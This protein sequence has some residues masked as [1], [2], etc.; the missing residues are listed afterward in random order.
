MIIM[1]CKNIQKTIFSVLT[2]NKFIIIKDKDLYFI[3]F[4]YIFSN[5]QLLSELACIMDIFL[6]ISKYPTHL[7]IYAIIKYAKCIKE[8]HFEGTVLEFVCFY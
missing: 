1:H 7:Y 4:D 8:I 2:K 3:N 5:K 6:Y